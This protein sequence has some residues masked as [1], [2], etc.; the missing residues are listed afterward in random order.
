[1][2]AHQLKTDWVLLGGMDSREELSAPRD[3][4]WEDRSSR[5]KLIWNL[6]PNF[7]PFGKEK[8]CQTVLFLCDIQGGIY[9]MD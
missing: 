8:Y 5:D 4:L 7:S 9:L 2:S 6:E 1:M 3:V